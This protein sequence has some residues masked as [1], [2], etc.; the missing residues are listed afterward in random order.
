M[1]K[2]DVI[3]SAEQV[4]YR[5]RAEWYTLKSVRDR[6]IWWSADELEQVSWSLMGSW[7]G[8]HDGVEWSHVLLSYNNALFYIS[9]LARRHNRS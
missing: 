1:S 7:R 8:L 4:E 2:E 9:C 5:A 6:C 3:V